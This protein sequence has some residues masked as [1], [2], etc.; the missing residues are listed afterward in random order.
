MSEQPE[1]RY[2]LEAGRATLTIDRPSV[3]NALSSQVIE[4]LLGH[5]DQIDRD[6]A[7]KVVVL[8]GAGEK[9]FCAGGD[10][11]S[12]GGGDGFL[13]NHEDRARFGQLLARF[14][15]I[16][17]PSVARVNGHALAGGLGLMLACDLAVAANDCEFGC[18]EIDRGLFPMMVMALLHRHL[19]RKRAL[20]LVL[21]GNR[22]SAETALSWGLLNRVVPRAELDAATA[23]LADS[24]AQKSPAILRLGRRA[25]FATEDMAFG[26]SLEHLASQLSLNLLAEDAAEGVSAYLQ[27]RKPEW[28]GK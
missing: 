22:M 1:V 26:L 13:P 6:P 16:G 8:T 2:Q 9:I 18:P 20:E 21:M 24:L 23:S 17:K 19:G 10:L 14:A 28:K 27:K 4:L 25:Y 15:Q 7:V 3:R 11:S 12:M 5:L